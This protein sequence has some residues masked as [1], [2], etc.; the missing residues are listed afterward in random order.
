M[1]ISK[2]KLSEYIMPDELSPEEEKVSW[3]TKTFRTLSIFYFLRPRWIYLG[4]NTL[5]YP[6]NGNPGG[7]FN[8][9]TNI[10]DDIFVVFRDPKH[11]NRISVKTWINNQW[12]YVGKKGFSSTEVYYPKIISDGTILY[13]AYMKTDGIHVGVGNIMKYD[14][15]TWVDLDNSGSVTPSYAVDINI[16]INNGEIHMLF[17]DG[18]IPSYPLTMMKYNGT[19]W[20]D[21][22]GAGDISSGNQTNSFS[23]CFLGTIPY[24]AYSDN[25][26]GY[27]VM[28]K[29][30]INGLWEIVGTPFISN[31]E[32]YY[33]SIL[34]YQGMVTVGFR[35][36]YESDKNTVLTFDGNTWSSIG[37]RGFSYQGAATFQ[38]LY[39]S[40][41]GLLHISFTD[42]TFNG[43]ATVMKYI[44]NQWQL[45][46]SPR[47]SEGTAW[48]SKFIM[49]NNNPYVVFEDYANNRNVNVM[50]IKNPISLTQ[51]F[52]K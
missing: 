10:N 4:K 13:V 11:N 21:F 34:I 8:I 42:G 44:N 28:V 49:V 3:F 12:K 9:T 33:P 40:E 6:I 16:A 31:D 18:R 24:V 14:G 36:K 7:S 41:N 35:D 15:F 25:N 48:N 45:L 29:R 52:K 51:L 27:K 46:S 39:V 47:F 50:T 23:M 30:F 38:N 17:R 19:T 32:G 37:Q 43:K 22:G 1:Q 20:T 2:E 5:S 26:N